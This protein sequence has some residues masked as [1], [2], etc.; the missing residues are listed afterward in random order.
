[1]STTEY[2]LWDIPSSSMIYFTAE[3]HEMVDVLRK[4][5][6]DNRMSLHLD[7][8]SLGVYNAED[9]GKTFNG[10]EEIEAWLSLYDPI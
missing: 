5:F 2:E 4:L 8:L 1:M 6:E 7:S 10:A 3:L 9:E